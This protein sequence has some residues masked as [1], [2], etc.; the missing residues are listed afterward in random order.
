MRKPGFK[1]TKIRAS[2]WKKQI[3]NYLLLLSKLVTLINRA[4]K[5]KIRGREGK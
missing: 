1:D 3:C 2:K 5:R 4:L